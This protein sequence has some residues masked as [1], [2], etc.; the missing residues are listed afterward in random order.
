LF[1][2]FSVVR[3]RDV[4]LSGPAWLFARSALSWSSRFRLDEMTF[5]MSMRRHT[6]PVLWW[7]SP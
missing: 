7:Q 4:P 6:G 2:G 1:I 5:A 3:A